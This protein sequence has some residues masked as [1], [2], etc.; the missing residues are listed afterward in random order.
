[1]WTLK[2]MNL[3]SPVG[4]EGWGLQNTQPAHV[5]VPVAVNFVNFMLINSFLPISHQVALDSTNCLILPF[6]AYS[7]RAVNME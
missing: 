7:R 3:F 5:P 4:V 1:M 2:N 6:H